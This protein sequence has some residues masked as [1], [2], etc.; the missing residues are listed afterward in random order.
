MNETKQFDITAYDFKYRKL[1]N[2]D[3][4]II[5]SVDSASKIQAAPLLL[6]PDGTP[7]LVTITTNE[8]TT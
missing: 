8:N 5:L 1:T 2:G 3:L 6:I 4:Q 7:L